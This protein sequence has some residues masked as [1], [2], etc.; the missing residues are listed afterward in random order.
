MPAWPRC[1]QRSRSSR[2]R[3]HQSAQ[4]SRL[5]RI[6]TLGLRPIGWRPAP[7]PGGTARDGGRRCAT[8]GNRRPFPRG[9]ERTSR[10][11]WPSQRNDRW[12]GPPRPRRREFP[13]AAWSSRKVPIELTVHVGDETVPLGCEAHGL[14]V[15]G[16]KATLLTLDVAEV[17]SRDETPV[18]GVIL[19][20]A[21]DE[22]LA[23]GLVP[24]GV[25]LER[26]HLEPAPFWVVAIRPA[27]VGEGVRPHREH[28]EVREQ[29][30]PTSPQTG[31]LEGR[32]RDPSALRVVV[33]CLHRRHREVLACGYL[34]TE[35]LEQ[36]DLSLEGHRVLSFPQSA[37]H[38]DEG[39]GCHLGELASP[40]ELPVTVLEGAVD[41]GHRCFRAD[42]PELGMGLGNVIA[43]E[44]RFLGHLPVG[45]E[46][47]LFPVLDP[48]VRDAQAV[49]NARHGRKGFSQG[50]CR[51]IHID[52]YTATP[53][54]NQALSQPE[55]LGAE[56][57]GCE[58]LFMEHEGAGPVQVP[59]PTVEGADDLA[60]PE[61]ATVDGKLGGTVSAGV[62]ERLHRAVSLTDDE[63][64]LI[65][66]L[67]F[68]EIPR[69]GDLFQAAGHLPDVRPE[70]L[71]L[72]F[73]KGA[74]EITLPRERYFAGDPPRHDLCPGFLVYADC[75]VRPPPDGSIS[76]LDEFCPRERRASIRVGAY[77]L[78][79]LCHAGGP[80]SRRPC[81]AHAIGAWNMRS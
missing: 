80:T 35:P 48:H 14:E 52:P 37:H 9:G 51:A 7:S 33:E 59:A 13:Q 27:S 57:L 75:H 41:S 5:A 23:F 77:A 4:R 68:H 72:E 66:D 53:G 31:V 12:P 18:L 54:L 46:D 79:L 44:E 36:T 73:V 10:R 78:H 29:E 47:G 65:D 70:L 39:L 45:I 40:E 76:R 43:L 55:I 58:L 22:R 11:T 49:Q 1:R 50:R 71:F 30:D 16:V 56:T 24:R 67:V 64:G 26:P 15:A 60:S 34:V 63:D 32:H 81:K 61:A 69:V 62:L 74:V 20:I 8:G 6:G 3:R 28:H 38:L 42:L 21:F 2:D 19:G 25:S 17:L